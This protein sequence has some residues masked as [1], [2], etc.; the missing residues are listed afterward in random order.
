MM[1]GQNMTAQ[2][3]YATMCQALDE[4]NWKYSRFEE[5]LVVSFGVNGDDLPMNFVLQ[6]DEERQVIRLM[7]GLPFKMP[8]DKRVEGAIAAIVASYGMV[9]GSFDYDLQSGSVLYRMTASFR[10]SREGTGL[11]AYLIDCACAMVDRYNDKFLA[12]SKGILTIQDFLR[13]EQ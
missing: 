7:S 10:G 2:Q 6:V 8:E 1:N 11:F 3:V 13:Q 9:D 4:R 5:D 12:I